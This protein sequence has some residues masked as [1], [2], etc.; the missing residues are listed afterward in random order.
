[1]RELVDVAPPVH[2]EKEQPTW[3]FNPLVRAVGNFLRETICRGLAKIWVGYRTIGA[4][5]LQNIKGPVLIA[6]NHVDYFESPLIYQS[7]PPKLRNRLA[8]AGAQDMFDDYP[9]IAWLGRLTFSAFGLARKEPILPSLKY[10]ADLVDKG[11]SIAIAPEGQVSL[12]GQLQ[13]FKSGI[14]LLAIELS[15]PV[16]CVSTQGLF[17]TMNI[18]Q[19]WPRRHTNVTVKISQPLTFNKEVT[20]D[21]AT[22][23]IHA[24]MTELA[25]G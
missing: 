24:V 11:W 9:V 23:K 5:N 13:K 6:F 7:L 3:P 18:K 8:I 14:G 25:K 22:E 21:Q 17:G 1:V 20:Y 10:V 4:E 15:L 19:L 2:S 12:D 16:I